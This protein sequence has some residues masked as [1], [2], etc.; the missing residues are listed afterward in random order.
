MG[1]VQLSSRE[2]TKSDVGTGAGLSMAFGESGMGLRDGFSVMSTVPEEDNSGAEVK[3]EAGPSC[4]IPVPSRGG[5][6][7]MVPHQEKMVQERTKMLT[8]MPEQVE[9]LPRIAS[10][11]FRTSFRGPHW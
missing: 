10:L 1:V 4:S 11:P 7:T 2:S 5:P 6:G 3:C 8:T 9:P